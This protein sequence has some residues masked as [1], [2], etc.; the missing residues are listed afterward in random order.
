MT[1]MISREDNSG[2]Q[3]ST[4]ISFCRVHCVTFKASQRDFMLWS[5]TLFPARLR[6]FRLMDVT[7]IWAITWQQVWVNSQRSNLQRQATGDTSSPLPEASHFP[8]F[9]AR[10]PLCPFGWFLDAVCSDLRVWAFAVSVC[11]TPSHP[12]PRSF[13]GSIFHSLSRVPFLLSKWVSLPSLTMPA[14]PYPTP[15]SCFSIILFIA[16]IKSW[17]LI[18]LSDI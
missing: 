15:S 5:V 11:N 16:I 3:S 2:E 4:H 6:D 7:S 1:W 9:P 13:C 14:L 12:S 8:S 17:H 18:Y 10:Q